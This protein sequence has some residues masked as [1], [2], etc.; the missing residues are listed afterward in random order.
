MFHSAF[1]V[2]S[3]CFLSLLFRL[4][5]YGE[6]VVR[7]VCRTQERKAADIVRTLTCKTTQKEDS[8]C[9]TQQESEQDKVLYE[10]KGVNPSVR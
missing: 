7:V 4:S 1:S 9:D 2:G 10:K 5:C 8:Q 3:Y 6:M